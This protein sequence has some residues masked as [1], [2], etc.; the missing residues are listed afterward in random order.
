MLTNF[1]RE[2]A[3]A[4]T[5]LATVPVRLNRVTLYGP[6]NKKCSSFEIDRCSRFA[7]SPLCYSQWETP[8]PK[9]AL[10]IDRCSRFAEFDLAGVSVFHNSR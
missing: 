4:I 1:E 5:C 8:V 9:K 10:D 2:N 7:G 6:C 3:A